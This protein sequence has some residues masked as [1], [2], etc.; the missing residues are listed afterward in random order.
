M[1]YHIQTCFHHFICTGAECEDTCCKGWRIRIDRQSYRNYL[2]VSGAF[3]HR[4]FWE[5]DHGR[6]S[7]RMRGRAC[8]FLNREGFCDIYKELGRKGLC[9]GCR[10]YPRH[11]ENYGQLQEV[12]LSLSC[13]EAARLILEDETQGMWKEKK[14]PAVFWEQ[15]T[16]VRKNWPKPE[17]LEDLEEL[18]RTMVCLI[19]DRSVDWRQRQA[20]LLALAHDFQRHWNKIREAGYPYSR[21]RRRQWGK[22]LSKRYLAREAAGRFARRLEHLQGTGKE[23]RIRIAAWMRLMQRM[24]P[25]LFG[26]EQKAVRMCSSLYHRRSAA[27]YQALCL[28]FD[29]AAAGLEQEWE[30]LMLYFV[31]TYVLGAVYDGDVYTKVKLAVFGTRIIREWCLFRYG[32]S[33]K[34]N[35]EELAGAAYRYSREVENCDEN[36]DL[37]EEELG[38]NPLF[39]LEEMLKGI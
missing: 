18:R 14:R 11:R 23:Q 1:N 26:W 34:I 37:L 25:V 36:L 33:G 8:A 2:Q 32:T 5:I 12:M 15:Q 39:G 22:R 38:Q 3:G 9:R 28:E 21:Q 17:L 35:R 31:N 20:M 13:P 19:K 4:L 6:R 16:A 7:F 24:E 27:E 10:E 30:N 29:E